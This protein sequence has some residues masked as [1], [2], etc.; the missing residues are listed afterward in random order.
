MDSCIFCDIF[1][2]SC[3]SSASRLDLL[4]FR[5]R[6]EIFFSLV[7]FFV[8]TNERERRVRQVPETD[9][10]M[11]G[12]QDEGGSRPRRGH[13]TKGGGGL[14]R[15]LSSGRRR[16]AVRKVPAEPQPNCYQLPQVFVL[17]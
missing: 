8:G 11:A 6:E 10:E 7:D 4:W 16:R 2:R 1:S 13:P 3:S 17:I 9:G 5:L 15:V 14:L 12:G